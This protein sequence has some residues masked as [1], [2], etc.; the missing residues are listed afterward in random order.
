MVLPRSGLGD[1]WCC[2]RLVPPGAAWSCL[3]DIGAAQARDMLRR[4][5]QVRQAFEHL[6]KICLQRRAC[7]RNSSSDISDTKARHQSRSKTSREVPHGPLLWHGCFVARML[8]A[9]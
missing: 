5:Q 2:L 1:A 7:I 8:R 6:R 9:A 3:V 4:L